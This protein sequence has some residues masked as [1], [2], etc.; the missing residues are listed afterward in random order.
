MRIDVYDFDHTLYDGDTIVDLWCFAVGRHPALLR[1]LPRQ[2]W[3]LLMRV[4]GIWSAGKAKSVFQCYF[5]GIHLEE[6]VE[7]FWAS[8][9][10][11]HKLVSFLSGR[12]N[13][14][15]RVV[16]SASARLVLLP[17]AELL[18][19]DA[20]IGTEIDPDTGVLIGENCKGEAKLTAIAKHFPNFTM[21]AMY[22]D[23][24][25]ADGPLLRL[26]EERYLVKKGQITRL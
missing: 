7:A 6:E 9:K 20:I 11:R 17:V 25:K 10:I 15:P 1:F 4:L 16:A 18:T 21:R 12:P 14:L 2:L 19:V 13:D 24:T 22:T 5:V 3:A 8:E 26:A 23:D